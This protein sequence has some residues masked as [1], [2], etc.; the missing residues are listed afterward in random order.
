MLSS[1]W[2]KLATA[3]ILS[4]SILGQNFST[5]TTYAA[6]DIQDA[7]S[8]DSN[9]KWMT[10]EYHAHTFNSDDAQLSLQQTLD[11]AFE[12]YGLDWLAISD[13]LRTSKRDDDGH[14]ISGGPIPLSQAIV[15]YQTKKIK[16]LKDSG[17][18]QGKITFTGFEWD[19]PTYDHMG[20]GI[21]DDSMKA[22][23]QFEYLFTDRPE[24]MFNPTDVAAWKLQDTKPSVLDKNA[25]RTAVSWLKTNYEHTS[26]MFVNHPSRKLS[27]GKTIFQISDIR[28]FNN[29]APNIVFGMEGMPGNQ[30]EPDRGGLN[31]NNP[32][33]KTY[34]GSDYMTAK[35]GGVWD[36]LLGEGRKFWSFANSDSHFKIAGGLYSSGYLPGEYS[37]NYTWIKGNDMQ[38]V[39]EGMRSGKS[40]SVHGDLINALDFN[41]ANETSKGEMGQDFKVKEGDPLRLTIRFK[42]PQTNNYAVIKSD[43]PSVNEKYTHTSDITNAVNV[44]HVDLIAG[45]VTG[46][47]TPG[48]DEY[49]KDTN[50]STKVIARFTSKDWTTDAEGYNV[51]TYDLGSANKNQYF[52]LRGTNLGINVAGETENGEPLMDDKTLDDNSISDEYARYLKRFNEINDR[53]YKDLWF[54]SNPIF[55]TSVPNDNDEAVSKTL[56][57]IDLGDT[58]A[59]ESDLK[60]PLAGKFNASLSWKSSN[61]LV[62]G[63]DGMI[64]FR[65]KKDTLVTLTATSTR[66]DVTKS[67][68]FFATVKGAENAA[69]LTLKGSL[70]T[71]DNQM[72][73]NGDWTNKNVTASVYA[74]VNA[75][76][77]IAEL[78]L[79]K[80]GGKNYEPYTND[81]KITVS[82]EGENTLLFKA[83]DTIGNES[84][85]LVNANIDRTKPVITLVG[86]QTINMTVGKNYVE[87]GAKVTDNLGV[88]DQAT[89]TGSVY[90]SVVG[91]YTVKYNVKDRAGNAADEVTRTV[92]VNEETSGNTG[93]NPT[94]PPK[95]EPKPEKPVTSV[96]VDLDA[97]K[98]TEGSV[99]DVVVFKVPADALSADG[100]I[101]VKVLEESEVPSAGNLEALSETVEFISTSGSKF[102][103][104]IEISFNYKPEK[105]QPGKKAAV[106]YY[107]EQQKRWIYIGG[108]VKADGTIAVSVNHFTKFAVYQAEPKVLSDMTTN[109][110]A[111]YTDR[112]IGMNVIQGYEDN[113]FRPEKTV[114]RAAFAKMIAQA[115][116]LPAASGNTSFADNSEIPAWARADVAAAVQAGILKGYEQNGKMFFKA[117]QTITRAEMSV[118]IA[119]ALNAKAASAQISFKDAAAIPAWAKASID[120]AV[121]AGILKGYDD[122][123]FKPDRVASR[124][125]AAAMIYRLLESLHI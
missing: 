39:L 7:K 110:A 36:A 6:T 38:A 27:G 31:Q 101:S 14:D 10:G 116:G 24:S 2:A 103:K 118:M 55:V 75:P 25:A 98:G 46:M 71:D 117:T 15:D 12:T 68:D 72:Y 80:D 8:V 41:I 78:S 40:F 26:Y 76:V 21:L 42:S 45:D 20:V 49:N 1:K 32:K 50:D 33:N 89:V 84:L 57:G 124:A 4:A 65:P 125:E 44:D 87:Q 5:T 85:W 109:W 105:V 115:L 114:T 13:H 99:K 77:T 79:S 119:N 59:L 61:N 74:S 19:M 53:N 47:T 97:S 62:L 52:R 83:T 106:Y 121:T 34:G 122:L 111:P 16:Q 3:V 88:N 48:T 9:G 112:L 70:K 66:G 107:H 120:T 17:K 30:M 102:N 51:I 90:S 28:D 58:N 93:P 22:S 95:V 69:G 73:K 11:Q 81:T 43:D 82:Q 108:D 92:N 104:P 23:S 94:I 123:S 113:T 86:D 96:E 29:I 56:S 60:L 54:Y 67:K 37:K 64:V 18:Y 91:T 63:D 100:K 35:V